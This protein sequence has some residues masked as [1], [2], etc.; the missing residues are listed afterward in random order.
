[1]ILPSV[2][3]EVETSETETEEESDTERSSFDSSDETTLRDQSGPPQ[4]VLKLMVFAAGLKLLL[5]TIMN[6]AGKVVV[7]LLLGLAG[8]A[9]TLGSA[10]RCTTAEN[11]DERRPSHVSLC[12]LRVLQASY[13]PPSPQLCISG[14]SSAWCGG[15]CSAAPSAC[16]SSAPCA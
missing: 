3:Q 9:P 1:M 10:P 7:T 12:W 2:S 8:T 11:A 14:C 6:T 13:C 4:F 5:T 16:C 15:G